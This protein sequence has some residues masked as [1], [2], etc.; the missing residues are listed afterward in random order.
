MLAT[1]PSEILSNILEYVV[2]GDIPSNLSKIMKEIPPDK[3]RDRVGSSDITDWIIATSISR[4]LRSLGRRAYFNQ[5][6]FII[7][8]KLLDQLNQICIQSSVIEEAEDDNLNLLFKYA[9]HIIAP[10][11][12]CSAASAFLTLSRYQAGF[13]NLSML[14]LW[15]GL[16]SPEEYLCPEERTLV[17][18]PVTEEI[19]GLLEGIGLNFHRLRVEILYSRKEGI[20][21]EDVRQMRTSVFPYLRFIGQQRARKMGSCISVLLEEVD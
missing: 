19:R 2:N 3:R 7:S 18:E 20:R 1:L 15:P 17:R 12:G 5:K 4:R 9:R 6:P 16:R 14:T 8:P 10:L 21:R 13:A 11:P